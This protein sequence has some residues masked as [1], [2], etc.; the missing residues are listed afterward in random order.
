MPR[1]LQ[2]VHR[3]LFDAVEGS[4]LVASIAEADMVLIRQPI[5]ERLICAVQQAPVE[6]PTIL[7]SLATNHANGNWDY[8]VIP[9]NGHQCD[10]VVLPPTPRVTCI[11]ELKLPAQGCG[12]LRDPH[13]QQMYMRRR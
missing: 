8:M 13:A 5:D 6:P 9:V 12:H 3:N 7:D 4:P 10:D 1:D 11:R 2:Q